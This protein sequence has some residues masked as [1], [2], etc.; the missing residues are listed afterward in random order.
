MYKQ[1]LDTID[2]DSLVYDP[3]LDPDSDFYSAD[4]YDISIDTVS[5][6]IDNSSL[7]ELDLRDIPIY[8]MDMLINAI[9]Y[10]PHYYYNF[11]HRSEG[12]DRSEISWLMFDEIYITDYQFKFKM[13]FK[14]EN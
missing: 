3:N 12:V 9:K 8:N 6:L 5:L 1:Y 14:L 7:Y 2:L 11:E 10:C 4:V 13:E